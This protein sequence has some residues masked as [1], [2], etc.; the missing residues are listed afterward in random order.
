MNRGRL[1]LWPARVPRRGLALLALDGGLTL[2]SRASGAGWVVVLLCAVAAV[3]FVATVWPVV[4]LVRTRVELLASPRDAT[5]RSP[6]TFSVLVHRAGSGVRLRL[7]VGGKAGGWVAA[8]GTCQGDVIAIP[9]NRGVLTWVTAELEAADPVGLVSWRRRIGLALAVP[10]EVG[11]APAA[12]SL[13][14]FVGVGT[15]SA[16]GADRSAVG[17]DTV[18][19]VRAYATGDPIRIVHWPATARWGEVMVKEMEDPTAPELVIVVDLR[20]QPDRTEAAASVAAGLAGAALQVGL[21]V[22]L[23]TAEADGPRAGP[24]SS[25]VHA[26]RR[27]AR[28]VADA[29][30]PEPPHGV[31]Q[32]VRVTAK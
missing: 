28:A 25:P 23:L 16:D 24:V 27:L 11:P 26:G 14:E 7:V 31:R 32:V 21:A 20:G 18:R 29:R 6:T 3:L 12:V 17:H 19:G 10:S 4:T 15:D 30:P 22:S 1:R 13:D 9:P 2:V 5:A 8:F